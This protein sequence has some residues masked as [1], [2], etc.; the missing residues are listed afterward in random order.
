MFELKMWDIQMRVVVGLGRA[1]CS[2]EGIYDIKC[3]KENT[4][5]L[6]CA[7]NKDNPIFITIH[8]WKKVFQIQLTGAHKD[9]KVFYHV[10]G[11]VV[12][13]IVDK[14]QSMLPPLD[15]INAIK[16]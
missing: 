15:S 14:L 3:E 8:I 7:Y 9:L 11:N 2:V 10:E 4:P 16:E 13:G 6:T 5:Y 12:L 1:L